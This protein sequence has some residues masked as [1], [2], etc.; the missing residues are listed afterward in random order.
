MLKSFL[1]KLVSFKTETKNKKESKKA[2]DWIKNKLKN[3]PLKFVDFNFSGFPSL[4]ILTKKTKNPKIF[5]AGHIDVV[6]AKKEDFLPKI[7]NGKIFARGV[8]DMKFALACYLKLL[9]ELAGNLKNYNLGLMITSDEEIG[10]FLG[11]KK[12]LER[13][14]KS[15][16][17]FLPDGGKNWNLE[18][19]AKGVWHL[20]IKIFGKSA[21]G[22]RPW[23]GKGANETL[24]DFLK[25]FK[26]FFPKEPCRIKNH[27]HKTLTVGKIEGGKVTNQVSD[28]SEALVDIRF[29][30]LS[31]KEKLK[32]K[33]KFLQKKYKNI[34]IEEIIF[35][36]P[37][38]ISPKNKYL[39]LFQKIIKEK[40]KR[41]VSFSFSHGSS[42]AR[43][44]LE[45]KIPVIL[46]RPKGGG[47]HSQ[48]EW[49]DLKDLEKYYLVLK[50]FVKKTATKES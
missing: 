35:A 25:E 45:K 9:K 48:K 11:T 3:L 2:I 31:Q 8:F 40:I 7:K 38:F 4:L 20:K 16:A 50:E 14:Y 15:K 39:L 23:E 41:K 44:F 18:I 22:S 26:N 10:G 33:I 28:F 30:S 43:F 37:Y 13:G 32:E 34:K 27:W 29:L 24:I 12:I 46:T 1:L 47:H 19:K 5:L 42:D 6:P 36:N 17:V 21:H 49:I